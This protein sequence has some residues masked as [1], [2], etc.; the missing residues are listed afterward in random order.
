MVRVPSVHSGLTCFWEILSTTA[1]RFC[2]V[3]ATAKCTSITTTGLSLAEGI[4][5]L[6]FFVQLRNPVEA[7]FE[8][9]YLI[10]YC[11]FRIIMATWCYTKCYC[12]HGYWYVIVNDSVHFNFHSTWLGC[13]NMLFKLKL[14]L[15][16]M[17]LY[18]V[19]LHP[20][21][22]VCNSWFYSAKNL[23]F[24]HYVWKVKWW[25]HCLNFK[26]FIS[27]YIWQCTQHYCI[28]GCHRSP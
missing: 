8:I 24:S 13:E 21:L 7:R 19:S 10:F 9:M 12:I 22:L 18:K 28:H 16:H 3:C 1:S 23:K 26:T 20:W 15:L 4:G 11:S 17:I 2:H 14:A 5:F 27:T 25:L 6:E